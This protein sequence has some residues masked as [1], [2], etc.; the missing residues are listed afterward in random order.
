M[1]CAYCGTDELGDSQ[2]LYCDVC[3][4]FVCFNCHTG[5]ECPTEEANYERQYYD[6]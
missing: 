5:A 1:K 3:Q 2:L 4:G 6:K